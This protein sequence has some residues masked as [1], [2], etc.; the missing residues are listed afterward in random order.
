MIFYRIITFY[1]TITRKLKTWVSK[2]FKFKF[3]SWITPRKLRTLV[4][5]VYKSKF[6]RLFYATRFRPADWWSMALI[7]WLVFWFSSLAGSNA[8]QKSYL[9]SWYAKQAG[10]VAISI[11]NTGKI[12]HVAAKPGTRLDGF[13][14]KGCMGDREFYD[15]T[16][17]EAK[18]TVHAPGFNFYTKTVGVPLLIAGWWMLMGYPNWSTVYILFSIF[19]GL[20]AVA[21]YCALRQVTGTLPSFV[22]AVMLALHPVMMELTTFEFRD[23]FRALPCYIAIAILIYQL[24]GRCNW[25]G[26]VICS[27]FLF[28]I[29]LFSSYF[30]NDFIVLIPFIIFAVIFFHG[31]ILSDWPKKA[32]I[33]ALTLSGF[34]FA[35]Y[36]PKSDAVY[37]AFNHVLYIG[38][39]D[40]PFMDSLHF[41]ADH[42]SKGIAYS[43][44]F[45]L[46]LAAGKAHRNKST[47]NLVPYSHGYDREI[48]DELD[49]LLKIYP[50]DF[51]RLGLSS[52][53]QSLYLGTENADKRFKFVHIAP[54]NWLLKCLSA[55]IYRG[56]PSWLYI[57]II[58]GAAFLLLG[59]K[60]YENLVFAA[61]FAAM[62]GCYLFQ[63]AL[64]HNFYLMIFSLLAVGFLFGRA[65]RLANLLLVNPQKICGALCH[66]KRTL[67]RNVSISAALIF[68]GAIVLFAANVVQK[69]QIKKEISA[70]NVAKTE[71][72][73]FES[74]VIPSTIKK[75]NSATEVLFQNFYENFMKKNPKQRH[76]A[77]FIKLKFKIKGLDKTEKITVFSK[78]GNTASYGPTIASGF[79]TRILNSSPTYPIPFIF[80]TDCEQ[81]TIYMP[82]YFT[83]HKSPLYRLDGLELLAGGKD[84]EIISVERIIDTKNIHTQSA[85]LVP[86]RPN[87]ISYAGKIDWRKIIWRK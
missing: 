47:V 53:W 60:F 36:L 15:I 76:F 43:D 70:F 13:L 12:K 44:N 51:L 5:K 27:I 35:S 72:I 65:I 20:T 11:Y 83:R 67:I 69:S 86:D 17:R 78:Y 42:Y 3:V 59:G 75:E 87:A 57:V 41:S 45:A 68:L 8:A 39:A 22:L 32:T 7:F 48:K 74:K 23:G 14:K 9:G 79:V 82:I 77:E 33:V 64:R 81:N 25:K 26:T 73:L 58:L 84:L 1:R 2:V 21:A 10:P 28:V 24:K 29:C 37:Q 31:K 6:G 50:Y 40:H 80:R 46:A 63:F 38:L 54:G 66:K 62:S 55:D 56:V 61:A 85:F 71:N 49:S 34:L 4:L 18:Q 52:S 16:D 19:C 30:R